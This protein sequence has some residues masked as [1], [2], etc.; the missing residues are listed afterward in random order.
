MGLR[1]NAINYAKELITENAGKGDRVTL[2]QG[3][4]ITQRSTV[5]DALGLKAEHRDYVRQLAALGQASVATLAA[6][7]GGE[8][9][10]R[11]RARNRAA[12]A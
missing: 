10:I 9:Y 12:F 5:I 8:R 6:A 2:A 11:S 4:S 3:K 7:L 1:D